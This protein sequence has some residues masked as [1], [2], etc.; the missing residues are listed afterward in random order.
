MV[1]F[2]GSGCHRRLARSYSSAGGT[3]WPA[4]ALQPNATQGPPIASGEQPDGKLNVVRTP[5]AVST[6]T[7]DLAPS[8]GPPSL[9]GR[10]SFQRKRYRP[11]LMSPAN[12]FVASVQWRWTTAG[13]I[14]FALVDRVLAFRSRAPAPGAGHATTTPSR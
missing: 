12:F 8:G 6:T 5:L 7:P 13:G 10:P 4:P 1:G 3:G 11:L 2:T 14:F 9:P